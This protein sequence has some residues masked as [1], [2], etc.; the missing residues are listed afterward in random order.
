VTTML[1]AD[2]A[3]PS[4]PTLTASVN[5][6]NGRTS[7]SWTASTDNVGVAGYRVYR[8][9]VLL[10]TTTRTSYTLRKQAGTFTYYIV[11]F[12]AAGNVSATS[13]SATVTVK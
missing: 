12:D 4:A 3:A 13:N 2:T 5:P 1:S 6:K 8:D 10:A 11:A 9:G 7:L